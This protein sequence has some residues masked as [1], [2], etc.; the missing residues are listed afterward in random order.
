VIKMVS[1]LQYWDWKNLFVNDIA[2][3]PDIFIALSF[4]LIMFL[5]AKFRF[6]NSAT[7]VIITTYALIISA[8]FSNV[9]AI[10]LFITA[11][12]FAW[13]LNKMLTTT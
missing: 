11:L 13:G 12:F 9:L 3:G 7:I 6:P 5:C 4:V 8:F 2:G 1:E 10:T